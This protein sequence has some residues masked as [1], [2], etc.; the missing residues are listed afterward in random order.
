M[1][2]VFSH[3]GKR[4]YLSLGWADNKIT[5]K[6]AEFKAR[7]IEEDIYKDRLDPTL[8]KY[9]PQSA[10]NII[11]PITPT[12]PELTLK[13]LWQQYSGYKAL[14]ASPKT[15][16]GTYEPVAAHLAKCSTD[17]LKDA[18]KFRM[19]LLQVTTQSQARR[20]LMQLQAACR[21]GVKRGLISTS[22][23]DGMYRELDGTKPTPPMA[24]SIQERDRIIA[25]FETDSRPG[26][27]YQHY[28]PLVKFLFWTGCRPCE[29]IG[30]RWGSV[31]D[32]CSRIHFH[33]SIVE[34]SG[35]LVRRKET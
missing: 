19:Q 16:N 22:P 17:G 26:M 9:K 3:G 4:H 15:I 20:T 35:K 7:Q 33:E 18:V 32:D 12:E 8:I 34:V 5:R 27:N 6:S 10:L 11:T 30:L 21:W 25:A 29:A 2:L 13:N 28:A 31:T 14:S 23:L 1:Q 24:F